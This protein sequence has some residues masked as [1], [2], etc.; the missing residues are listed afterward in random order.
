[1][2]PDSVCEKEIRTTRIVAAA[3]VTTKIKKGEA[4]ANLRTDP[5]IAKLFNDVEGDA[6]KSWGRAILRRFS[7]EFE[8][9]WAGKCP[10]NACR[11]TIK[12]I[13]TETEAT[14]KQVIAAGTP[15][16][17]PGKVYLGISYAVPTSVRVAQTKAR[18]AV[19]ASISAKVASSAEKWIG[20]VKAEYD[21]K[22]WDDQCRYEVALGA[23]A[24]GGEASKLA[25]LSPD[26]K[27]EHIVTEVIGRFRPRFEK[28]VADGRNREKANIIK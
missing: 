23:D 15:A 14:Q 25:Q 18:A 24:M 6:S 21:P 20:K 7:I 1:M 8:P 11:N 9:T 27:S 5:T 26:V 2:C 19:I 10:D 12:A 16:P 28:A 3:V 4:P 13:R 17:D 22:C